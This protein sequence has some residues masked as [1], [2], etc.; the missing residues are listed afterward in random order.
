MDLA[1]VRADNETERSEKMIS[2]GDI[3]HARLNINFRAS[4]REE[5]E[6]EFCRNFNDA[7]PLLCGPP[8]PSFAHSSVGWRNEIYVVR[9]Y[10]KI[11]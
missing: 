3:I 11:K 8:E 2:N 5:F 6:E 7:Q 4:K 9:K 1:G 10:Q